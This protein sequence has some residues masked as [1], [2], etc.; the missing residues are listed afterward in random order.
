MAIN[1]KRKAPTVAEPQAEDLDFIEID[2][3]TG[4]NSQYAQSDRMRR[5]KDALTISGWRMAT[6][7]CMGV[8]GLLLLVVLVMQFVAATKPI[9]PF[10]TRG[11]GEIESLEYMAGNQRSPALIADFAR[12][13]MIGIFTWRNTLPV[14]GNPPDPGVAI[15]QG[16]ISTTSY[17]YTF[18]LSTEFAEVFRVKLSQI[19]AKLTTNG[20]QETIYIPANISRPSEVSPGTWTVDVVGS[21][22]FGKN[23]IAGNSIPI[24]RRLTIRAVP[25]LTLSEALLLYKDKGLANAVARIRAA[26]LEITNMMPLTRNFT[27][28]NGTAPNPKSAVAPNAT[29]APNPTTG[30]TPA[31]NQSTSNSIT[32]SPA[33]PTP[34]GF[35]TTP[36]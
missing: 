12:T 27:V 18:G 25:P 5:A 17:R 26:G 15:G 7:G 3:I 32:P 21:M 34:A 31:T 35:T 4:L 29:T 10:V 16:K 9:S 1:S 33:N 28:P 30:T 22:Y 20:A 23:A 2:G 19:S 36:K 6:L 24:N 8:N 14:E 13:Q 11:N